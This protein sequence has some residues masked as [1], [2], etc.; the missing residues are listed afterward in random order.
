MNGTAHNIQ[1]RFR[2]SQTQPGTDFPRL[3]RTLFALEGVEHLAPEL[4]GNAGAVVGDGKFVAGVAGTRNLFPARGNGHRSVVGGEL[5]RIADEI[6]HHAA[7]AQGVHVH[8][9]VLQVYFFFEENVLLLHVA[10]EHVQHDVQLFAQSTALGL[11][12]DS[13]IA[14]LAHFE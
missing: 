3:R 9:L 13:P 12:F 10:A 7:E 1:E 4:V 6:P 8:F 14:D 11:E 2:D 5:D